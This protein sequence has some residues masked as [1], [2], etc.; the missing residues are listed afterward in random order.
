MA[1]Y[2]I[3]RHADPAPSG[4]RQPVVALRDEWSILAFIL[5]LVWLLWHRLWFA[6]FVVL[7]AMI[8]LGLL[9]IEPAYQSFVLPANLLLNFLVGLE[10]SGWRVAR[11]QARGY[12][13]VDVVDART[14]DEA[15]LRFA[16]GATLPDRSDSR[17]A[18]PAEPFGRPPVPDVLFAPPEQARP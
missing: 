7:A 5:P 17:S 18:R 3:M 4:G 9:A 1:R 14:R 13:V 12:A 11:A 10:A 15:E 6:A 16:D 8:A 2:V